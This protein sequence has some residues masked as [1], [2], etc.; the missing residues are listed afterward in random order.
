MVKRNGRKMREPVCLS[1]FN[2]RSSARHAQRVVCS[3]RNEDIAKEMCVYTLP[4]V[5]LAGEIITNSVGRPTG[6]TIA[7]NGE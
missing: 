6:T 5:T 1:C 3:S 4:F 7:Y 2:D